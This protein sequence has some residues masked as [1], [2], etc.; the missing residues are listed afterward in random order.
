M[1]EAT[2][3]A[4]LAPESQYVT[5]V[6]HDVQRVHHDEL[7][8]RRP[9][10]PYEGYVNWQH[11]VLWHHR[12]VKWNHRLRMPVFVI[13]GVFYH[14]PLAVAVA[15]CESGLRPWAQNPTSTASGLFQIL[16]GPTGVWSNTELA[17]RMYNER[18][19]EPW[20]ASESCWG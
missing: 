18:G 19:W 5:E 13:E 14:I 15:R 7:K 1:G 9:L 17:R 6:H 20:T 16:G 2:A 10:T 11:K 3:Q 12:R 8:L 4:Q